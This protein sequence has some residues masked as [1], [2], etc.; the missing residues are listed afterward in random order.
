VQQRRQAIMHAVCDRDGHK[1]RAG[2]RAQAGR[3]SRSPRPP[4]AAGTR[5]S[6]RAFQAELAAR[7]LGRVTWPVAFVL[8]FAGPAPSPRRPGMRR[9]ER[10]AGQVARSACDDE[11][12]RRAGLVACRKQGRAAYRALRNERK[13]TP[14]SCVCKCAS[15]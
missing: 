12:A 10:A 1:Q 2:R 8:A 7:H 6:R 5:W 15:V 14:M 3:C 9:S 13:S 4:E 11:L